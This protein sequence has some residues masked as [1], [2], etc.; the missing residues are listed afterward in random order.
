MRLLVIPALLSA[1]LLT[2]C[3]TAS[4]A[5]DDDCGDM[6]GDMYSRTVLELYSD[7]DGDAC[8]NTNDWT[9]NGGDCDCPSDFSPVGRISSDKYAGTAYHTVCLGNMYSRAV[10]ELYSDADGD[11]CEDR[12]DWTV[13][14]G[15]CDCPSGFS[16]VGRKTGDVYNGTAYHTV[17]LED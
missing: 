3:S 14:G 4:S 10:L 15:D 1:L 16:P 11:E 2:S 9:V 8:T 17:C 5:T 7:A 13:N 12:N 6:C